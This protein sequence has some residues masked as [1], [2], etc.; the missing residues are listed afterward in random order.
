MQEVKDC[1]DMS[2]V[3]HNIPFP[4]PASRGTDAQVC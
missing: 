2:H 4:L 3:V 1:I